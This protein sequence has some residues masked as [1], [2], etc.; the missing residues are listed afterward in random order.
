MVKSSPGFWAVPRCFEGGTV[1]V[2]A[3]GETMSREVA[4][5][6]R[7]AGVPAIAINA[8]F[9]LAPWAWMLYGA[10]QPWWD[11]KD[12]RDARHF[13]G[14]KV[15]CEPVAGVLQIH[16]TGTT[17]FDPDPGCVRTGG[18]SGYQGV[19]IA[20][21]TGARRI[22]L[23]GFDMHGCHWHG[24]HP[25]GLKQTTLPAYEAWRSRFG[26]LAPL[27]AKRGVDV[28][29]CTPGSQLACFRRSTLATELG[30]SIGVS[31]IATERA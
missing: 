13:A 3:S 24:A 26:D 17:G 1:A 15:S 20:A 14:L 31:A 2:L 6:V 5:A 11:H 19:H 27:L 4:D 23:C 10:D 22:L 8:T 30:A 16:N 28:V 21:H 12:Y 25:H 18:N 7:A 9:R 29:N